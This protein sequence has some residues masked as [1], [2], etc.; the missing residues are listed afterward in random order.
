MRSGNKADLIV[1]LNKT[2]GEKRAEEERLPYTSTDSMYI[3]DAM[4]FIQ[5]HQNFGCNTFEELQAL[6]L[7]KL[8]TCSQGCK[9]IHFVGDRYDFSPTSSLKQ[10]TRQKRSPGKQEREYEVSGGT[11]IPEWK[12]FMANVKNKANLLNFIGE[13]WMNE[14]R[15]I[16]KGI[17]LII[18]GVFKNPEITVVSTSTN[19]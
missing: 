13:S 3:V 9:Y 17:Q 4:A 18:G 10:E 19:C 15:K 5:R 6:Y 8:L 2:L 16:P 12:R 7:K 14:N 1:S 11:K